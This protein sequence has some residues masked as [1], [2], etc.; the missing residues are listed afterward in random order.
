MAD[1]KIAHLADVHLAERVR[2]DGTRRV[3]E[4]FADQVDE[5]RP[6]LVIIAGDLVDPRRA[7]AKA[8]PLERNTFAAVVVRLAAVAPVVVVRGNHDA[9]GDWSFLSLLCTAYPVHYFE[10]PTTLELDGDG[11]PFV[12]DSDGELR[13]VVHAVP[14]LS[15]KWFADQVAAL[16]LSIEEGHAWIEDAIRPVFDGIRQRREERPDVLHVGVGHLS[17][18][19]GKLANGQALVGHE[20]QVGAG[21]LVG[22]GLHYFGLGHLHEAQAVADGVPIWYAGSPNRLD[23]GET[24]KPCGFVLATLD[25]V[26]DRTVVDFVDLPADELVAL[27]CRVIEEEGRA[28][29]LDFVDGGHDDVDGPIPLYPD[30]VAGADV[31]IRVVVPEGL[32]AEDA[33]AELVAFVRESGGRPTVQRITAAALRA[34]DGAAEVASAPDLSAKVRTYLEQRDH[35]ADQVERVGLRLEA[36]EGGAS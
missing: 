21:Q 27:E 24:G 32:H 29:W 34:R 4:A 14:W 22:L 13:A 2:F 6:D 31:R 5:L 1:F 30:D 25:D 23:F 17:V 9:E 11:F 28:P 7:P 19:G 3:L 36:L 33:I 12:D 20:V 16:E 35:P 15:A 8:T 26:A 10:E 18:R